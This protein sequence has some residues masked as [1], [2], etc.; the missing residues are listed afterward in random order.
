MYALDISA[1]F[2]ASYILKYVIN[3]FNDV[4]IIC[5]EITMVK[6]IKNGFLYTLKIMLN[7]YM[8]KNSIFNSTEII[9]RFK[10]RTSFILEFEMF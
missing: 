3:H 4:S 10:D 6:I 9:D 2:G 1:L 7:Y 5:S 8:N